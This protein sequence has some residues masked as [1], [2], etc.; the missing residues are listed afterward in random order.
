MA[1]ELKSKQRSLKRPKIIIV[2]DDFDIQK[3]LQEV[4]GNRYEVIQL[5]RGED[6]TELANSFEPDLIVLDVNLPDA[7]GFAICKSLRADPEL[8]DIPILFM[9]SRHG[10]KDFLHGLESGGDSYI[11]KPFEMSELMERI[12]YLLTDNANPKAR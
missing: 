1:R 4:L 11:T 12:E 3:T 5:M 8:R 10:E 9:T 7:N 2:D 6:I